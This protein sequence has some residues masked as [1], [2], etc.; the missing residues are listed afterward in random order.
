MLS[1]NAKLWLGLIVAI[2]LLSL[3]SACGNKDG[4]DSG[5]SGTPTGK[6]YTA[7]KIIARLVNDHQW[8]VGVVAHQQIGL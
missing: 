5:D 7:A 6:T 4:D 3:A 8:R 1:R 2:S